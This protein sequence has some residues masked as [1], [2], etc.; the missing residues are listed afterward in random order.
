MG[1]VMNDEVWKPNVTVA[2]IVRRND[3]YLMVEEEVR[4]KVVINQPAGHLEA[5]ETLAAAARRETFEETAYTVR[6]TSLVGVYQWKSPRGKSFLRAVFAGEVIDHDPEAELDAGI[7]RAVWLSKAELQ[8]G[9]TLRSP[10]VLRCVEEYESGCAFPLEIM[11]N[12]N[13]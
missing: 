12:V 1:L 2:T 10:M 7:L 4:G 6:L 3:R 11:R 8:D 9:R 5:D 13:L